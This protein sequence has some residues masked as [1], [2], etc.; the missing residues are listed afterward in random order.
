MYNRGGDEQRENEAEVN[1]GR[2]TENANEDGVE[3]ALSED[4][5]LQSELIM[6]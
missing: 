6:K 4:G 3:M 5:H 1:E 2:G